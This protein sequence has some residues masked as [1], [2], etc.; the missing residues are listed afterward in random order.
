MKNLFKQVNRHIIQSVFCHMY[1]EKESLLCDEAGK[2]ES[3]IFIDTVSRPG[4]VTNI[5]NL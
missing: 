3:F 4:P 2:K 1:N 5:D